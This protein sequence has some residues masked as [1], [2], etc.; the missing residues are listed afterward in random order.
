MG[1]YFAVS[2]ILGVDRRIKIKKFP[3]LSRTF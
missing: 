1:S 2:E 3:E